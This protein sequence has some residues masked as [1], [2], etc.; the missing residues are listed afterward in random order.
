LA[1]LKIPLRG[2][3]SFMLIKK[4]YKKVVKDIRNNNIVKIIANMTFSEE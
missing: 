4:S 2:V 1:E 3:Y